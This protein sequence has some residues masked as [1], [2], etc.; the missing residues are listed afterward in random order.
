MLLMI[1]PEGEKEGEGEG[2]QGKEVISTG[3]DSI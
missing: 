1:D 3:Q 2:D